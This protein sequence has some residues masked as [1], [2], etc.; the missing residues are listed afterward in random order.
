M[1][2]GGTVFGIIGGMLLLVGGIGTGLARADCARLDAERQMV[3][4]IIGRTPLP[5]PPPS[6]E[7]SGTAWLIPSTAFY[8]ALNTWYEGYQGND[9]RIKVSGIEA[10]RDALDDLDEATGGMPALERDLAIGLANG[11]LARTLLEGERYVEGYRRGVDARERLLG[12]LDRAP[13][14]HAGRRDAEFLAGLYE[15]YTHDLQ[16][17]YHWLLGT[18][19]Y[20]GDRERGIRLIEGAIADHAVFSSEAL[21]ALL[22][23]VSWRL[24]DFCRYVDLLESTARR[25]GH[26]T[27]LAVLSQGL[28]LRCGLSGRARELNAWYGSLQPAF[29]DR[30][31]LE[32]A[33]WRILA[34]LGR[35]DRLPA[36][37]PEQRQPHLRLSTAYAHD[38]A[39]QRERAVSLYRDLT[40]SG[41]VGDAFH[42]VSEVR[43]RYP[44]RPPTPRLV[45]PFRPARCGG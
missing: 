11:H 17:R 13:P 36:P 43:L 35:V 32:R 14:D 45:A 28:M 22:A 26:N 24:P 16:N 34:D 2:A 42:R 30:P 23:E 6:M 4:A 29:P 15:V 12:F 41:K 20:R 37:R 1:T 3:N 19:E 39:G 38:V 8:R 21:R 7:G 27:D 44:Y 9:P 25:F 5:E 18:I 31:L 10:L 40:L 33:R